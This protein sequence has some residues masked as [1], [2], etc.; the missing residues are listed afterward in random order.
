MQTLSEIDAALTQMPAS[1]TTDEDITSRAELMGKRFEL[2]AAEQRAA[3][4]PPP[5][6]SG[7]VVNAPE[8]VSNLI[9]RDGRVRNVE[10]LADGTRVVTLPTWADFL[11][12]LRGSDG[13]A[14]EA[15]NASAIQ[16]MA[17]ANLRIL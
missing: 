10:V 11:S 9:G 16:R 7:I 1:P 5:E 3:A 2:I 14:W 13:I 15:L 6:T 8:H 17:A 12:L 4:A